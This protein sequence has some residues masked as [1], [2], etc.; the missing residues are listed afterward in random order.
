MNIFTFIS[1][2]MVGTSAIMTKA[3]KSIENIA[4]MAEEST[5]S[6]LNEQKEESA[7]RLQKL[8]AEL[9]VIEA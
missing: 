8:K 3:L 7:K 5:G 2:M 9:K 4:E 1:Q 6:M